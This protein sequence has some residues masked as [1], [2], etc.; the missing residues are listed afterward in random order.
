MIVLLKKLGKRVLL[1]NRA[2]SGQGKIGQ[3]LL[4]YKT[5]IMPCVPLPVAINVSHLQAGAD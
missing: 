3:M 1:K 5:T 4:S 2:T